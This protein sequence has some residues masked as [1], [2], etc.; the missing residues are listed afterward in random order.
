MDVPSFVACVAR[1]KFGVERARS[2]EGHPRLRSSFFMDHA[3]C[4]P[5]PQPTN[6]PPTMQTIPNP[7][8]N[9]ICRARRERKL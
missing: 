9:R 7:V 6:K 8:M 4:G 3:I 2:V 1:G 5:V